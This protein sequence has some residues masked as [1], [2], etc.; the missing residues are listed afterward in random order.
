[1]ESGKKE[2]T[3]DCFKTCPGGGAGE[4]GNHLVAFV[5]EIKQHKQSYAEPEAE[6]ASSIGIGIGIGVIRVVG[7]C[8]GS[9][10][11]R[12]VLWPGAGVVSSLCLF[13]Q[14]A[15]D[16]ELFLLLFS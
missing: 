8:I 15:R 3:R 11:S 12:R 5:C 4:R 14:D 1:M 16:A 2:A 9:Q 7:T 13:C 10:S 6:T